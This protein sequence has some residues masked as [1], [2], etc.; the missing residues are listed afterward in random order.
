LQQQKSQIEEAIA[1]AQA[2]HIVRCAQENK[3]SLTEFEAILQPIIESC[4]K[5]SISHGNYE[6]SYH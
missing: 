4:T 1:K 3:V 2:E 6:T 5:E